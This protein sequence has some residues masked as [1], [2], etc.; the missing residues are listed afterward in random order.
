MSTCAVVT[1]RVSMAGKEEYLQEN[2]GDMRRVEKHASGPHGQGA[3]VCLSCG[4]AVEC[5]KNP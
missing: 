3:S 1:M 4:V 2:E 5:T